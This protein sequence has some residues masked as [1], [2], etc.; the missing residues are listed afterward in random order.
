VP[1][2][3]EVTA[4][5][6][7][8]LTGTPFL[9]AGGARRNVVMVFVEGISGGQVPLLAEAQGSA[10][11]LPMAGLDALARG[12]LA[13]TTFFTHQRQSNRGLYGVMCGD[14]PGL[15]A[16]FPKMTIVAEGIGKPCLPKVLADDGYNT[17]FL[18]AAD[19][20][21]MLMGDFMRKVGFARAM[22]AESYD[23]KLPRGRWGVDDG[24]LYDVGL[25]EIDA[26]ARQDK[27][28]FVALFTSSTHH[29]Y[30][31]PATFTGDPGGGPRER[32]WAFAD[33]SVARFVE[34]LGKRGRLD[35][36]LVLLTSDE[37]T[38]L[39]EDLLNANWAPMVVL[40]PEHA[41]G[42][43]EDAYAQSDLALSVL[44]YLGLGDRAGGFMGRSM[45]RR[46][47]RPR[48]IYA[49]SVYAG[50][51]YEYVERDRLTV[52]KEALVDCHLYRVPDGRPFMRG[53]PRA[54]GP[55]E[56]SAMMRAIR[57]H[58]MLPPVALP[59]S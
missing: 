2:P 18:K 33:A 28:F 38:P 56:A 22:G 35:D 9:S 19:S 59:G 53:R 46:Y 52:C 42:L 45:F 16:G 34:E 37:A 1:D 21:F 40:S 31:V 47:D 24:T 30:S 29:P 49:G 11:E 48:T 8:D 26:L 50:L 43:V 20:S 25:A 12:N 44:D 36:T 41:K 13:Y 27:P 57:D 51:I 6:R 58:S 32:A 5:L 17:L 7:P 54:P 39:D 23:P 15:A 55:A 3:P 4:F 10:P 14:L